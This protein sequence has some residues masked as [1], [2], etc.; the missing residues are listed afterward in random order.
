MLDPMVST[1]KM[2][3][4]WMMKHKNIAASAIQTLSVALFLYWGINTYQD[5]K[6]LSERLEMAQNN[7]EAYQETLNGS[8]LASNV[9]RL[10]IK[11]LQHQN[12]SILQELDRV[13]KEN[14]IKLSG[15][16]TA[17][18]QTQIIDVSSSKG[19]QGDLVEIIKDT[20]Y[21]DSIQYNPLTKVH[22][23]IGKDTVKIGLNLKNTQY[24]Y[25]YAK[26]EYKNKKNFFKRLITFDWK[27]IYKYKYSIINTNDLLQTGDVRVVE[28]IEK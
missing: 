27:K 15:L 12:D 14:K 11:Q 1:L 28:T 25:I 19:V 17:A 4:D 20:V 7:I 24:L 8:W 23:C 9:L 21:T 3:I 10:D 2:L 13:R 6:K 18:T 5:N 26:K 22:Y 16:K